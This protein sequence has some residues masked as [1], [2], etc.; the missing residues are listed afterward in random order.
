MEVA[1]APAPFV[2]TETA[3]VMPGGGYVEGA[4]LRGIDPDVDGPAVTDIVDQIR[5]GEYDLGETESGF[6]PLIMGASLAERFAAYPGRVLTLVSFQ[7]I[8]VTS[9]GMAQPPFRR[10]EVVGQFR[11]G[12]YE[13][14]NKYMYTSIPAAQEITRLGD[15]V[16]GLEVRVSDPMQAEQIALQIE[17]ELGLPYRAINWQTENR[18]LFS[19]LQLEKMAMGIILLLIVI[20][21]AFNIIST[22]VMVVADKTREIGIL[23]SMGLRSRQVQKVFMLQG[24]LIGIVGSTLGGAG[25]LLVTWALDHYQFIEI[26][27]EVY[28]IDHLPVAFDPLEIGIILGVSLLIS[29]L[30]TIYP[31]RQS[32]RLYPV[33][34]IRHE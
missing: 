7:G 21:A 18:S 8:E 31:A 14:D 30:A 17:D 23:K 25:G 5:S 28:F 24:L 32:A 10:F 33:K 20:V 12:M 6:P 19:A 2:Q 13:F 26:P 3:V 22:L 15:A 29:F 9:L 27:V 4:I 34:A 11:T 1:V 16:T